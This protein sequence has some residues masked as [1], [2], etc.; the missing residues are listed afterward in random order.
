LSGRANP[1]IHGEVF[2]D[3]SAIV[4]ALIKAGG[5]LQFGGPSGT[6][7]H[8]VQDAVDMGYVSAAELKALGQKPEAKETEPIPP[9]G[10]PRKPLPDF[11][12]DMT[13]D[14]LVDWANERGIAVQ[15]KLK[16]DKEALAKFI[17]AE[18]KKRDLQG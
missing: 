1:C 12:A 8:R 7:I 6:G 14:E 2:I 15:P 4:K 18:A 10:E 5:K 3:D 16:K 17:K 11:N 13:V 9:A